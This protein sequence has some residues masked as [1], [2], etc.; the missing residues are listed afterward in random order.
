MIQ[1]LFMTPD[2]RSHIL[3]WKFQENLHGKKE[4]SIPFQIQKLFARLQLK[5]FENE[6]TDH[7]TKSFQWSSQ[8]LLEQHDIQELCRVLF[9]AIE[10]SFLDV[11]E[12]FI[13]DLYSGDTASIV[14]CLEC[15]Y[16]SERKDRF[17]DIS[18]PVRNE[19]DKIYNSSL[20]M[21]L[22]NML[23]E[24][25]LEKENQYKCDRCDKKVL[26]AFFCSVL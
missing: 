7:L 23:R 21:A 18:L 1:T 2:F 17:L 11:E 15:G 24:E 14:R 9:E 25:K 10:N 5:F 4:D 26:K 20:E 16:Q 6:T 19:F 12:N 13:N 8:Q 22:L 3:S